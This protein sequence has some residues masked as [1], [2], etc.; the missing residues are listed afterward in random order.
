MLVCLIPMKCSTQ[1]VANCT[2]LF[3]FYFHCC[4]CLAVRFFLCTCLDASAPWKVFILNV[5]FTKV[6][7]S[8]LFI[9]S[10]R[11]GITHSIAQL[12]WQY[13]QTNEF[14]S[15]SF[16]ISKCKHIKSCPHN[17]TKCDTVN[18]YFQNALRIF[19]FDCSRKKRKCKFFL[20]IFDLL[21]LQFLYYEASISQPTVPAMP[22]FCS[23]FR[24]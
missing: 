16:L 21:L 6:N 20:S 18:S 2:V 7:W 24:K 19:T 13:E 17:G 9:Y 12:L 3:V 14:F 10:H 15:L 1:I 11:P 8:V 23:N 22:G 5:Q 4:C